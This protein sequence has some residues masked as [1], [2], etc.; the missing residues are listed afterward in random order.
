MSN[1][2]PTNL[3]ALPRRGISAMD[4]MTEVVRS[5]LRESGMMLFCMARLK[6]TKAN[7][8]PPGE[9]QAHRGGVGP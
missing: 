2:L 7:S 3:A 1:L 5:C 9:E 4:M 8:P 6:L